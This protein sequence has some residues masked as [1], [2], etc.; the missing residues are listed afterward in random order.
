MSIV[1]ALLIGAVFAAGL[2]PVV[3]QGGRDA[4]SIRDADSQAKAQVDKGKLRIGDGSGLL[5]VESTLGKPFQVT[6]DKAI[7]PSEA[8][9]TATFQVPRGRELAIQTV[10]VRLWREAPF[11]DDFMFEIR[12]GGVSVF[13]PVVKQ[14]FF[15]EPISPLNSADGVA[16]VGA[17]DVTAFAAGG[18]EVQAVTTRT[19][20]RA[21]ALMEVT[22]SGYLV[23]RV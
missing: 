22:I 15:G 2:F 21:T 20:P 10:T 17:S 23:P 9:T 16:Y 4:I 8:V 1:V 19:Q 13:I 12:A 3:A 18:S 5:S 14:G 7:G 11:E 6:L